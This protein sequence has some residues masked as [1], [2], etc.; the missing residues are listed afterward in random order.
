[1]NVRGI[2]MQCPN[3][4]VLKNG[5]NV[6]NIACSP[7]HGAGSR[8]RVVA[9]VAAVS[10]SSSRIRS[11]SSHRDVIP[12]AV[13]GAQQQTSHQDL[14]Q[15]KPKQVSVSP[16]GSSSRL[17][18]ATLSLTCADPKSVIAELSTLLFGLGCNILESDQVSQCKCISTCQ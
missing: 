4:T 8:D 15:P 13:A 1:M 7:N 18:A 5:K 6:S 11:S 12:S 3:R 9:A 17:H 14:S 10:R 16:S 2:G